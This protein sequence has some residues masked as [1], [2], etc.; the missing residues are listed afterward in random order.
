[1]S[2]GNSNF[3]IDEKQIMQ[4][5]QAA[6]LAKQKS[7]FESQ[8][9]GLN[10]TGAAQ[11][12][13][14]Q[15]I[16]AS[17]AGQQGGTV[18]SR[19][20]SSFVNPAT[21]SFG[22]AKNQDLIQGAKFGEAVLGEGL[23]RMSDNADMQGVIEQQKELAKGFGSEEMVARREQAGGQI[24]RATQGSS[25]ALQAA[26]AKA[27]VKGG[28]AGAKLRDVQVGGIAQKAQAEQNLLI[29]DRAARE[30][31]VGNLGQ[32]VK[33]V[34]EFDIAQAGAEKNI[35]LQAGLGFAGLGAAERGATEAASAARASGQAQ[36]A[37]ACFTG[38]VLVVMADASVKKIKDIHLGDETSC[39]IVTGLFASVLEDSLYDIDGIGVTADH[40][41]KVG[42]EWH[43]AKDVGVQLLINQPTYVYDLITVSHRLEIL[44]HMDSFIF[45]DYEGQDTDSELWL[46][47][48]KTEYDRL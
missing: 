15:Q 5:Q 30:Q 35:A 26:L 37:A 39:G 6:A 29:Q 47:A 45:S 44:G 13:A 28:A 24:D 17:S 12:S 33:G 46:E 38:D 11:K 42:E 18:T 14:L 25:R 7:G 9:S 1:M 3:N 20:Q 48:C 8:I 40:P 32:T 19:L 16:Q 27:G 21:G 43:F 2:G 41:V 23:G 22:D 10:A 31:S 36:A 34:G 4:Q